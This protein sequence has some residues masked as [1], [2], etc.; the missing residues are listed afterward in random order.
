MSHDESLSPK[1]RYDRARYQRLRAE[2]AAQR[3]PDLIS[4]LTDPELAYIAGLTDADGSVYVTHTNRLRTY[5]PAVT[6]AMIHRPTIDWL[7][8]ALGGTKVML[9]NHTSLRRGTTSWGSS[10][11][12]PQWRT[13]VAGS[14]AQLLC[15][16]MHPYMITKREQAELVIAFPVDARRAP[17]VT[18][19]EEIRQ[20]RIELG[21][22]ISA[23]N[24]S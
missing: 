14:R 1:Q 11:F 6:W 3:K 4:L 22:Q 13:I 7:C 21:E 5:Y 9:N 23:L 10:N 16:R 2:K 12:R 17:G 18:L 20:R 19:P 24:H 15:Q 8:Q